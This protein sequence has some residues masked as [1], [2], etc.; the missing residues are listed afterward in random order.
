MIAPSSI[1]FQNPD[2]TVFIVDIPTSIALAQEL[3]GPS[4]PPPPHSAS[5]SS[6]VHHHGRKTLLSST[7][8]RAPYPPATEPKTDAARARVLERIPLSER[9]FHAETIE[10]L[11]AEKLTE[12]RET[13]AAGSEFEWCLHRIAVDGG[14]AQNG[15]AQD[16]QAH[17]GKRKRSEQL[18]RDGCSLWTVDQELSPGL[19]DD[20]PLILSPGLNAFG[21]ISELS[22]L[23]VKNT[24][25]E[26]ATVQIR[27]Q[28]EV[29]PAPSGM[30]DYIQETPYHYHSFHVPP[31][32][33]F[34][35]C[36][37]PISEPITNHTQLNPHIPGLSRDHRFDLILLDPPWTNRS[38][39]RS[40]HYRTQSYLDWGLLTRRLR[41]ILRV[42]LKEN[43]A[44]STNASRGEHPETSPH[45]DTRDPLAAIWITNS[46][47]ARKAAYDS[48]QGA[49]LT[50]CEEW[51]WLKTTTDGQPIS[52]LGGHWRK[53]YEILVIGRR[54]HPLKDEVKKAI[55]TRRV[56]AAVPD[57]HS[58]K[59][60]LKELFEKVFFSTPDGVRVPYSALEVFARNLT[61]GWWACGDEALKFNSEEWLVDSEQ[62][63]DK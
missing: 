32:S 60:N 36:R 31:L 23:V 12:L 9:V 47:K 11:V 61:A 55:I 54:V 53:P 21:S 63:E 25:V 57:I 62:T 17:P 18:R 15:S 27:C 51:V 19:S 45:T 1:L 52:S 43:H 26:P 44:L 42:H 2:A 59:P 7:P 3:S 34:L 14:D 30:H 10:P 33:S 50:V 37:L 16:E 24:S 41:D 20:P 40:G 29:D 8:I 56:I 39:R 6:H 38:V 48:M 46:A 4:S 28:L 13:L 58:R 22:H 5:D 49:G 35:R